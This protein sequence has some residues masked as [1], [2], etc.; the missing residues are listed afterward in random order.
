MMIMKTSGFNQE[1]YILQKIR[2][3][4]V[5]YKGPYQEYAGHFKK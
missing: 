3:E 2:K 5:G 1:V 4:G